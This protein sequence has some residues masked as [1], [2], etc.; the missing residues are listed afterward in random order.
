MGDD[1]PK[2]LYQT[3]VANTPDVGMSPPPFER[4]HRKDRE[5]WEAIATK[6]RGFMAQQFV[7]S[8]DDVKR[9]PS[10]VSEID[11]LRERWDR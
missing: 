7:C 6:A 11:R 4:L 3:L 1:L 10:S 9:Q 8:I 2:L 5:T